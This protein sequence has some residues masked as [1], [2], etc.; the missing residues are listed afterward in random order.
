MIGD[1]EIDPVT[2]M[3]VTEIKEGVLV[4]ARGPALVNTSASEG[5]VIGLTRASR[6]GEILWGQNLFSDANA[7]AAH[8]NPPATAPDHSTMLNAA[9]KR[10]VAEWI[11]TGGKY[12]NDPF[13]PNNGMMRVVNGLDE[14]SFTANVFP[15]LVS[16]CAAYCHQAVGSSTDAVPPGTS[17]R[18]NRFVLTGDPDGDYGVTLT[19]VSDACNPAAN[20]LLKR[21]STVPHPAGAV[22]VNTAVLPVGSANYNAIANWIAGGC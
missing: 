21:P 11:D 14:T 16:T 18:D 19:M 22:G 12:Y 6:L 7:V 20:E 17:F 8:P 15:I 4:I 3:P 2:G 1:P 5:F 10:V 13:N 9:E